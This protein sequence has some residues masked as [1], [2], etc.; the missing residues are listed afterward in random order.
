MLDKQ[1]NSFIDYYSRLLVFNL[2]TE[3]GRFRELKWLRPSGS[4]IVTYKTSQPLDLIPTALKTSAKLLLINYQSVHL[5]FIP[6]FTQIHLTNSPTWLSD[7]NYLCVAPNVCCSWCTKNQNLWREVAVATET[8]VLDKN[9]PG[10]IMCT[11]LRG[12]LNL[13]KIPDLS[14]LSVQ[15]VPSLGGEETL[16]I[17]YN[18]FFL[19]CE[20]DVMRVDVLVYFK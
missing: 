17:V 14:A 19:L 11:E 1:G 4:E 15:L 6:K 5:R 10:L 7:Q 20:S 3:N 2:T 18:L 12:I 13:K 9:Q 8:W 16:S